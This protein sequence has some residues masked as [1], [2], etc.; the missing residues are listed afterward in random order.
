ML[1]LFEGF[2]DRGSA[3]FELLREESLRDNRARGEVASQNESPD[4]IQK[5]V[6][7]NDFT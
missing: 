1:K 6:A 5:P 3:H 4:P 2:P 7:F